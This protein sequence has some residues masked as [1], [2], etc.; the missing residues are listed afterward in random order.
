MPT[1][2]DSG[3]LGGLV[4]QPLIGSTGA[5]ASYDAERRYAWLQSRLYLGGLV[6]L[7]GLV[8]PSVSSH[9][10]A[11]ATASFSFGWRSLPSLHSVCSSCPVFA[12]PSTTTCLSAC[13]N[14][15]SQCRTSLSGFSSSIY[16]S[17]MTT[18]VSC[19]GPGYSQPSQ[20]SLPAS[21]GSSA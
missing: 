6:I 2:F 12:F 11:I 4:A 3:L 17:S 15:S 20:S 5:I 1:S 14:P 8:E 21:T 7:Y 9:G 19:A 10:S 16:F 13:N 18:L